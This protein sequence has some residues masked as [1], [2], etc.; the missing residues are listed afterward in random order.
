MDNRSS[1]ADHSPMNSERLNTMPATSPERK[2]PVLG[3]VN[4]KKHSLYNQ[5]VG[6]DDPENELDEIINI[7]KPKKVH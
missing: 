1:Y 3:R 7:S 2:S 6:T 4:L 5:A